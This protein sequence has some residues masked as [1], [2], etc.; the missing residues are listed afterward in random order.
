MSEAAS[1]GEI[2]L[3]LAL[4]VLA[5]GLNGSWNASFSPR[6][7]LAVGPSDGSPDLNFPLAW[8]LFQIYATILNVPICIWWAGGPERLAFIVRESSSDLILVG[9]FS[10]L[11]GVGSVAFGIACKV[12]GVG[13]GTNLSMG[14]IMV[15]GTL[16]PLCLDKTIA[17]PAGGVVLAGLAICCFGLVFAIR[18]LQIRDSEE[19]QVL[20]RR[21]FHN[22]TVSLSFRQKDDP[23]ATDV[24]AAQPDTISSDPKGP[25]SLPTE[26]SDLKLDNATP[27]EGYSTLFKIGICFIAGIFATQLQF[28]FVFGDDMIAA[29]ESEEGPGSTPSS[30]TSAV[31]WLFAITLGAPASI[32]YGIYTNPSDVPLR[33]LWTCPWYRHLLIFATTSVPWVSHIH[34]Y[35]YCTTLLPDDMGPS[36]AWPCLMMMTVVTGILWS[37]GLGEWEQVSW[38]ARRRLYNGLALVSLGIAVIMT[39]VAVG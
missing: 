34:L 23:K 32:I 39:S 22:T 20:R 21:T 15:L 38:A 30:G 7:R 11:W 9:F 17:T 28:A 18:S 4:V 37:M 36:V 5:G 12:A 2:V 26:P 33:R 13:L 25:N 35:G 27:P 31:V 19:E 6:L 10:L 14:V 16:L 3:G 29:A 1:G 24:V 8:V